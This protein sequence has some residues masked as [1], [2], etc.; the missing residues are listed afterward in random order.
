MAARRFRAARRSRSSGSATPGS[1]PDWVQI[2]FSSAKTIYSVVVYSLQDDF[3]VA[4]VPIDTTR[5]TAY[6]ITDFDVQ[7]WNGASWV[8]LASVND[9]ALVKRTVNFAAF[10]TDRIRINVISAFGEFARLVEV[11]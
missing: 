9:N 1:F 8:T 10:A 11:Q 6:G 4:G 3:G 2:N 5:F 7:G